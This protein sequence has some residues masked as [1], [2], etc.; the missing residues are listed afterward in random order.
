MADKIETKSSWCWLDESGIANVQSKPEIHETLAHAVEN[1]RH[2]I[3][4]L[5][6]G[7]RAMLV[8]ARQLKSQDKA[9]LQYYKSALN[10]DIMSAA[11]Y[12]IPS[13]LGSFIGNLFIGKT[14]TVPARLFTE[15]EPARKWLL[16]QI[17]TTAKAKVNAAAAAAA[18]KS[19]NVR[20]QL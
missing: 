13:R 3:K 12:V 5:G 10:A 20:P 11:A 18:P 1:V 9:A 7:N 4:L 16:E 6:M 17:A 19:A 2:M 14:S 15:I 8:D